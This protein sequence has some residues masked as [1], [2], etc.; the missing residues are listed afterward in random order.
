MLGAGGNGWPGGVTLDKPDVWGGGGGG[1]G[2]THALVLML[3]MTTVMQKGSEGGTGGNE[4]GRY[5]HLP[6][7][8]TC[9]KG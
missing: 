3:S 7:M 5:P 9:E 6:H 4:E 2:M 8:A 1:R